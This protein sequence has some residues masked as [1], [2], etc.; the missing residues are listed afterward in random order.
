MQCKVK[1]ICVVREVLNCENVRENC[2]VGCRAGE[3]LGC[4]S[5][6]ENC[7]M[8]GVRGGEVLECWRELQCWM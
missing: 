8:L 3:V 6:R 7:S 2:S 1:R 4:E 5:I